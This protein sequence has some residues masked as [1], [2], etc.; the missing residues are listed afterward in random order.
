MAKKRTAR[1]AGST[2]TR[3]RPSNRLSGAQ[4]RGRTTAGGKSSGTAANRRPTELQRSKAESAVAATRWGWALAVLAFLLPTLYLPTL[5]WVADAPKAAVLWV[6]TGAG[7]P[8]LVVLALGRGPAQ[9]SPSRIWAARAAIA[10]VVVAAI[11]TVLSDAPLHSLVGGYSTMTGLI[12]FAGLA[13][14]WALGAG[15]GPADRRL[16]ENAII[17]AGALNALVI[18]LERYPGLAGIGLPLYGGVQPAGL[19]GNP[20]YSGGLLAATLALLATR[21]VERPGLWAPVT[22]LIAFGTALS[23]ERF[24][25]LVA[26]GVVA[27]SIWALHRR[28]EE[29]LRDRIT[30]QWAILYGVASGAALA[31][32]S[33][34]PGA[35]P[36]ASVVGHVSSSTTGETFDQRFGSWLAGLHAL[37]ERPLFGYGPSQYEPATIPHYSIS[38]A[39]TTGQAYFSDAHDIIVEVVVV[40]GVLGLIALAAWVFFAVRGRGGPLMVFAVAVLVGELVEPMMVGITSLAFLALGAAPVRARVQA[41]TEPPSADS[42]PRRGESPEREPRTM[43]GAYPRWALTSSL[44]LGGL[45]VVAGLLLIVGDVVQQRAATQVA[46]ATAA[47]AIAD[48]TTANTLL[49]AWPTPAATLAFAYFYSGSPGHSKVAEAIHYSSQAIQRDPTESKYWLDL[50]TFQFAAGD[51]ASARR[52]ALRAAAL[53]PVSSGP[54]NLLADIASLEGDRS[55]QRAYLQKSLLYDPNQP[56]QRKYLNGTCHPVVVHTQ[57]GARDIATKCIHH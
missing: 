55:A 44:I 46:P 31:I 17:W 26:I 4:N 21:V 8:F 52:S 24:P 51:N 13:A 42:R 12:F 38:L 43:P 56:A 39:R 19:L 47:A 41:A 30:R 50:A 5:S 23:G 9:D 22:A 35:V 7:L 32:G 28:S 18:F 33:L 48:G 1:N 11:A 40:T 2:T 49:Q 45:A 15:V 34:I 20:V 29:G 6:L 16:V 37:V 36:G 25:I 10:F 54:L 3:S 14:C 53:N 57:F 27:W